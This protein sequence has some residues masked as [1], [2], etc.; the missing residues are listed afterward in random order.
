MRIKTKNYQGIDSEAILAEIPD[1]CPVCNNG[2]NPIFR[3]GSY[4]NINGIVETVWQCPLQKCQRL[5]IGNYHK[6]YSG[7]NNFYIKYFVPKTIVTRDFEN[8]ILEI[9]PNFV[10]IYKQAEIAENRNLNEICGPGYRKALE[11]LIKDYLVSI[12]PDEQDEIE[13]S[14]LMSC[15]NNYVDNTNIKECAKR[16][17]WLGNDETH[18]KRKWEE[19]DINDLKSIIDL[20]LFWIVS[21]I[22]TKKLLADMVKGK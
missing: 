20:T 10:N 15:I 2:I 18:Y 22:K 21:E 12:K 3:Y 4:D 11:F 9:S 16:A 5:F 6:I 14:L 7:S 17:V 8:E 13:K 1:K 19:K